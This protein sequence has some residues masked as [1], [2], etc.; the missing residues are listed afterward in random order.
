[1]VHGRPSTPFRQATTP[2]SA[3]RS[4]VTAATFAAIVLAGVTHAYSARADYAPTVQTDRL[5]YA[6]GDEVAIAGQGFAPGETVTLSAVH[7]D[8]TAEPGLG[9]EPWTATADPS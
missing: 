7:A 5:A 1:M 2:R 8:G 3:W 6:A 4:R 9:H